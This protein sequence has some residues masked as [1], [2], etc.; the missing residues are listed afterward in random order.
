MEGRKRIK[1][2]QQHRKKITCMRRPACAD[3]RL[4]ITR[5]DIRSCR[6]HHLACHFRSNPANI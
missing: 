4:L 2:Q 3:A 5:D 6:R 1:E